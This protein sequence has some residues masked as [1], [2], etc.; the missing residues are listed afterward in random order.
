MIASGILVFDRLLRFRAGDQLK[1]VIAKPLSICA[2][3][4][5]PPHEV[6]SLGGV[7]VSPAPGCQGFAIASVYYPSWRSFRFVVLAPHI[8]AEQT[9]GRL[10][11]FTSRLM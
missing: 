1:E 10:Y 8:I 7:G 3:E 5:A 9:E 4:K 2:A 11:V 6:T